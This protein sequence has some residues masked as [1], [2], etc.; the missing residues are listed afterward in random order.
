MDCDLGLTQSLLDLSIQV[1]QAARDRNEI[2]KSNL[3]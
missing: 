3:F 1:S 2:R